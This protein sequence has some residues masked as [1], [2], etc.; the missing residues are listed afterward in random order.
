MS[1]V[2][3]RANE[4]IPN[5]SNDD[6]NFS[7]VTNQQQRYGASLAGI[8]LNGIVTLLIITSN[9][10]VIAAIVTHKS[11]RG[12]TYLFIGNLAVNDLLAG[13]TMAYNFATILIA[14][15]LSFYECLAVLVMV[16]FSLRMSTLSMLLVTV[17]QYLAIIYPLRYHSL[18]TKTKAKLLLVAA[19]TLC[20]II[21]IMPFLGWNGEYSQECL[22]LGTFSGTF[23]F[24]WD[25]LL[26]HLPVVIMAVLYTRIFC[27]AHRHYR[28]IREQKNIAQYWQVSNICIL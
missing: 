3:I 8:V 17:N 21:Y 11:L 13:L 16:E 2:V 12:N 4:S 28:Q 25:L 20:F 22:V 26:F 18:M 5:L 15:K 6:V 9:T 23:M 1:I 7:S 14:E 24:T 10:L 19:W 27:V